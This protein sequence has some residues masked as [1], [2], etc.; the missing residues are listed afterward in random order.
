MKSKLANAVIKLLVLAAVLAAGFM[1]LGCQPATT[2]V[3]SDDFSSDENI[4]G[5]I[6]PL[7]HWNVTFGNLDVLGPDLFQKELCKGGTGRCL[8]MGGSGFRGGG[9][10]ASISTKEAI[11]LDVGEYLFEFDYGNNTFSGNTLDYAVEGFVTGTVTSDSTNGV[12]K[13]ESQS[14]SVATAAVVNISFTANGPLDDGGTIID[15]VTLTRTS[16]PSG[17]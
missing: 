11:A 2:V 16:G 9:H 7:N 1:C 3:F 14:F 13:T 6:G 5:S 4:L 15:S 17:D 10:N 8:D 12:F